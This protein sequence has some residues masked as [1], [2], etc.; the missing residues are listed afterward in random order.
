MTTVV[1][2][3]GVTI[4]VPVEGMPEATRGGC[5]GGWFMCEG[6]GGEEGEGCCPTGYA[7]GTASC[8]ATFG[9]GGAAATASVAKGLP[10]NGGGRVG[11]GVAWAFGVVVMG[12]VGLL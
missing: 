2:G 4:V 11:V 7:C 9:A 1:S 10:T 12:L 5:A 3:N 6:E 8:L